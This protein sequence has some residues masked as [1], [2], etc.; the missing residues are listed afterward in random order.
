MATKP[1]GIGP[2]DFGMRVD[3][4]KYRE[5]PDGHRTT[6]LTGMVDMITD[7]LIEEQKPTFDNLRRYAH[8][9]PGGELRRL[10][11]GYIDADPSRERYAAASSFVAALNENYR[12][13]PA[14]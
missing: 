1:R 13:A 4:K 5:L 9:L 12:S 14:R 8:A 6:L 10:M 7:Y 3:C 11:D 2:K